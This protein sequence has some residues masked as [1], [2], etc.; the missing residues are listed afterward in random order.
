MSSY[1][2]RLNYGKKTLKVAD[3]MLTITHN[4]VNDPKLLL[5]VLEKINATHTHI[6]AAILA[7]ELENKRIPAF[8]ESFK[9]M[10]DLFRVR[11]VR[12]YN[13]KKNHGALA[14]EIYYLLEQHK[15]SPVEFSRKG[16]FVICSE[17]YEMK[18]LTTEKLAKYIADTKEFIKDAEKMVGLNGL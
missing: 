12:R 6:I 3:H 8:K 2:E 11:S 5:L 13:F 16:K 9:E 10:L 4:V 15:K 18:V 7:F 14:R 1:F 17:D